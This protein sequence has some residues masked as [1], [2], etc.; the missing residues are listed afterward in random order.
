MMRNLFA[1]A[2]CSL[3]LSFSAF[4]AKSKPVVKKPEA[5]APILE[6]ANQNLP[7]LDKEL[8]KGQLKSDQELREDLKVSVHRE[9]SEQPLESET[10]PLAPDTE[11][12]G[13]QL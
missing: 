5:A 7:E 11:S 10:F 4:A 12:S 6:E 9:G 8:R 13:E 2:L 3:A 1:L